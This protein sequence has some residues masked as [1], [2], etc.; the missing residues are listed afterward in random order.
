M[1]RAES[2]LPSHQ[3]TRVLLV[4]GPNDKHVVEHL[5]WKRFGAEPPFDVV[6]KGGYDRLRDAIGPELKAPGRRAVGIVV[7]ANDDPGSRWTAVTDLLRG[8]LEEVEIKNPTP[9]GMIVQSEPRVGVWLWPDNTSGGEIEE[10]VARMIP[11]GDQ[12]WPLSERYIESIP[13][14]Q[15]RFTEKKTGRAKLHAWLATRE[16]PRVMGTAI[17]A[18]DLEVNGLLATRFAGW[19]QELFGD[20][21]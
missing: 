21:T 2:L 8:A 20:R 17:R 6:D 5:Y 16:D 19:L 13:V 10:F 9:G 18:G 14:S 3:M 4:E 1:A 12:V 15:R 11:S 7:D